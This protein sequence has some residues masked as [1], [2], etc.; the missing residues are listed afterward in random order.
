MNRN[1]KEA[2]VGSLADI[3][4]SSQVGFLVDYRG[5]N[6]AEMTELRRRLHDSAANMRILKNRIAKRAVEQTPFAALQEHMTETRALIYGDEP[7]APAKTIGKYLDENN[8]LQY[9]AGVLVKGNDGSLLD[10]GRFKALGNLPSREQLLTNLLFVLQ[11][12]QTQFVRTLN[13]VPAKF[14]RTL[15]ALAEARKAS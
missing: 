8:K 15:A 1:E 2:M 14:V 9:V 12:T 5:L 4:S 3:F 6:V 10:A 11:G 7:V 13:E